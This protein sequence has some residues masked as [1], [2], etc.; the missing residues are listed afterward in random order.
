MDIT[1]RLY[2]FTDL[3][4]DAEVVILFRENGTWS[5][6]S[7]NNFEWCPASGVWIVAMALE[8]HMK[9]TAAGTSICILS[10]CNLKNPATLP[11]KDEFAW[12][13]ENPVETVGGRWEIIKKSA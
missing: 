12:Y 1:I 10:D 2:G 4:S 5:R 8:T 7:F 9:L 6:Q 3:S 11:D 13:R